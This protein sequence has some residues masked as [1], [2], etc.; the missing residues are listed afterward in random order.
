MDA[1]A[2]VDPMLDVTGNTI[3]LPDSLGAGKNSESQGI[4]PYWQVVLWDTQ[5][6][7]VVGG[8]SYHS[9]YCLQQLLRQLPM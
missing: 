5:A 8:H 1:W 7:A 3:V 6:Q 4:W 2:A 9:A